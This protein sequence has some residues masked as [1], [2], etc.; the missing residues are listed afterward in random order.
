MR[1]YL[2]AVPVLLLAAPAIAFASEPPPVKAPPQL[3]AATGAQAAK[4]PIT[5]LPP[6]RVG[7]RSGAHSGFTRVVFDWP[8]PVGYELAEAGD[9]VTLSFDRKANFDLSGVSPSHALFVTP[10]NA[11]AGAGRTSAIIMLPPGATVRH[12]RVGDRVV[13]DLLR[14]KQ[15]GKATVAAAD[16]ERPPSA[17]AATPERPDAR[18]KPKDA[19]GRAGDAGATEERPEVAAERP[20][21]PAATDRPGGAGAPAAGP[22]V[23]TAVEPAGPNAGAADAGTGTAAAGSALAAGAAGP[24]MA[25]PDGIAAGADKPATEPRLTLQATHDGGD[26]ALTFPW[27]Q[28]VKAAIFRR[29]GRL[30]ILFDRPVTVGLEAAVG[31]PVVK[32]AEQRP[33]PA[34]TVLSFALAPGYEP[35]VRRDGPAWT[36]ALRLGAA[37]PERPLAIRREAGAAGGPGI[38]IP[39]SAPAPPLELV[40]PEVGDRLLVVALPGS[41]AGMPESREHPEFRLLATAQG[42][43]VASAAE[44]LQVISRDRAVE[45]TGERGLYL[46][47]EGGAGALL[48]PHAGRAAAP[49]FD[50]KR[51]A[52]GDR[53]YNEARQELQQAVAGAAESGVGAA[54]LALARFYFGRGFG[55]EAA[56][57][58]A[59]AAE[60]A[61]ALEEEPRFRALRGASSLLADNLANAAKDL[62]HPGLDGN[63]EAALWRGALHAKQ[64]DPGAAV[65]GFRAGWRMLAD[66]PGWLRERLAL[67]A[68]E[69]ALDRGEARLAESWLAAIDAAGSEP[70]RSRRRVLQ[71]RLLAAKGETAEA[72]ALWDEVMAGS[73]RLA[74]AKAGLAKLSL[75][76]R[77]GGIDRAAAID[78]LER[79]RFAWRGD[80]IEFELLEL[81]GRLYLDSGDH[82]NGLVTL[83]EAAT[84]FAGSPEADAAAERMRAAFRDLFV[85]GAA[86]NLPPLKAMALYEE[87][88]D[89][90]PAGPEGDAV[91]RDLAGRLVAL[92]LLEPAAGL[93][94]EQIAAR[95]PSAARAETAAALA[96]VR[97]LDRKPDKALEAI[98]LTHA[99]DLPDELAARRRHLR[100]RALSELDRSSEALAALAGDESRQADALRADIYWKAGDWANAARSYRRVADLFPEKGP[101]P[102]EQARILLKLGTALSLA[103]DRAGLRDLADRHGRRMQGTPDEAAFRLVTAGQPAPDQSLQSIAAALAGV[104][105]FQEHLRSYREA[106]RKAEGGGQ[107]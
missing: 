62:F 77:D 8:G 67:L 22:D 1:C 103:G 12:F 11:A 24:A 41:G 87:F 107:G 99:V 34:A 15:D 42:I 72:V 52:R 96:L 64:G 74:R 17:G 47:D 13:V 5:L 39:A 36:V 38:V 97:L 32:Q 56:G 40:D 105:A 26:P 23:A 31:S 95:P 58:L 71:G 19:R 20:L 43:A 57:E 37:A 101:L 25:P 18:L 16:K 3:A 48:Q 28:E 83:R 86:R 76:L 78:Q 68:V 50:L 98:E 81:L 75:Q 80:R 91:L 69:A 53:R 84:L 2:T 6:A 66:Y 90:T 94:Q 59:L 27:P 88:R 89:L 30:W 33:H 44:Q 10:S 70:T 46:S 9:R 4:A 106:L 35:A 100:A 92:D 14:P 102:P 54:R 61:P 7:V 45:I 82:W 63:D 60:A 104:E 21:P 51:W 79:L 49:L 85:G 55:A 29:A 93:L 73:D 65:T